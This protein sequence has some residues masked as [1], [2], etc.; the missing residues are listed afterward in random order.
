MGKKDN[1]RSEKNCN[2]QPLDNKIGVIVNLDGF[3]VYHTGDSDLI[4]EMSEIHPDVA[5]LP[6]SG[7]YVMTVSEAIEATEVLQ[8]KLVIPMHFGAIVG[9]EEMAGEFKQKAK[10]KVEIPTLE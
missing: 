5:L 7:T 1:G 3:T 10:V 8:P 6:V 2:Y 9:S 4:P